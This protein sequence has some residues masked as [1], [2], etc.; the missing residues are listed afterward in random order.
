[1]RRLRHQRVK[2]RGQGRA[3]GT[4]HPLTE[5]P[6]KGIAICE[7]AKAGSCRAP[8]MEWNAR[9]WRCNSDEGYGRLELV[10]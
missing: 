9:A 2:N 3:M 6:L 1:M 7:E 4:P 8:E 10:L 5:L